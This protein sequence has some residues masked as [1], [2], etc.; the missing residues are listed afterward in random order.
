MIGL[1]YEVSLYLSRCWLD[2][3][4]FYDLNAAM[5]QVEPINGYIS[6][7]GEGPLWDYNANALIYVDIEGHKV[8]RLNP[9]TGEEKIWEVGERVGTVVVR[10]SGGMVIA[11]DHG[12]SFLS[13]DGE[14]TKI[15]DPEPD[16]ANN[17]F[18]DGKCSPDGHFFAGT[19]SLVKEKGDASLYR[20]SKE[21][22]VT[23]VYPNVTNSNGIT[24]SAD[25]KTMFY[26][27]TPT[28]TVLG[29]DYS[30]GKI[31]NPRKVVDTSA[32]SASPDGMAIDENDN[33]WVAFCHGACVVCYDSQT[34][35]ELQRVDIPCLE[36][37]AC[38]FGGEN[39]DTLYVTT[40]IHKSEIEEHAGKVFK[41]TG[42]GVKGQKTYLY[43]G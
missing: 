35:E 21:G 19:I 3:R 4:T 20:L 41:V 34:G 36:T 40:G 29:F 22:E 9:D 43:Q 11:G 7:W 37:T 30:D 5:H 2:T 28:L 38:A 14:L 39:L 12:F 32:I 6:T 23:E 15:S 17:R 25:G 33:L 31:S 8:I 1:S 18:N 24:W 26:I 27:D 10:K 13:E 42:L 16:K